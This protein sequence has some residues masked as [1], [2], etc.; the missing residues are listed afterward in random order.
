MAEMVGLLVTAVGMIYISRI[1]G[2]EYI[3]FSAT[4]G[5]IIILLGRLADGGLTAYASQLLARDDEPLRGLLAIITPPKFVASLVLVLLTLTVVALA[6]LN[7]KLKYF[8]NVTVSMVVLESCSPAWVFVA[9]GRINVASVI[10][11]VQ[12]ILYAAAIVIFIRQ[13]E[14]WRHLPYLT[15][16]NSGVNFSLAVAFLMYFRLYSL[17][18]QLLG[19]GYLRRLTG[20]YREG[21]HFLKADLS[22]YVYTTSDRLILYYFTDP[23]TVGIYEAA[24]KIINPFYSINGIITPTLFRELAQSFK[25]GNINQVMAKYVF[26]MSILSIP[27]GFYLIY[28]SE[29]VVQEVYGPRFAESA[30]SLVI[31]GFVITFGFTSGIIAQ[32]FCA[33][34]MQR[35]FGTSVFWGNVVNTILNFSLIP[36]FGAVG[37][38]I[39]TLAAKIIVTVVS[40]VYFRRVT[41][42]PIVADFGWFFLASMVPLLPV[43]L[44]ARLVA[45]NY[46]MTAMYG[47]L[48]FA[49]VYFI[50]RHVFQKRLKLAEALG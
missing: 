45:N 39:A 47:V 30:V 23:H 26:T 33:W 38:A 40:Y 19:N 2:P 12:S 34:K 4:S 22:G 3:G 27:L 13:P 11:I 6:P 15:I 20:F 44:V 28:F 50:Y 37:A 42:Y 25:Q 5:A 21:M 18:R 41:K 10:R 32:P 16:F 17:D 8:L 43:L 35:E 29:F 1:V 7:E 49:L 31:L 46:L 9:L 48:Y 24:Y 36:F 14:D